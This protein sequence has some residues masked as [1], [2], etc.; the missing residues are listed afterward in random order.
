MKRLLTCSFIY[1]AAGVPEPHIS[2][3]YTVS[4]DETDDTV[5]TGIIIIT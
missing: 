4:Q 2:S 5:L 1:T 3:L